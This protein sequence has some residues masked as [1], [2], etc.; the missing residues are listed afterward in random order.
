MLFQMSASA[1]F[2]P[3][4]CSLRQCSEAFAAM[5]HW[6]VSRTSGILTTQA[7]T[8]TA[9]VLAVLSLAACGDS[10]AAKGG[11]AGLAAG[12]P[13]AQSDGGGT[14]ALSDGAVVASARD[15]GADGSSSLGPGPS[16]VGADSAIVPGANGQDGGAGDGA[17]AAYDPSKALPQGALQLHIDLSGDAAVVLSKYICGPI[18]ETISASPASLVTPSVVTRD[19]YA[20]LQL[21]ET[22]DVLDRQMS[23]VGRCSAA[24][25]FVAW[26]DSTM[27]S[28]WS[29]TLVGAYAGGGALYGF[30]RLGANSTFQVLKQ[31]GATI[32]WSDNYMGFLDYS[33]SGSVDR[34]LVSSNDGVYAIADAK[35]LPGEAP[36]MT[37]QRVLIKYDQAG[38]R[39]WIHRL[40]PELAIGVGEKGFAADAAGNLYFASLGHFATTPSSQYDLRVEK[41][42]P[43]GT[44]LWVRSVPLFTNSSLSL[45]LL[46]VA[47]SE[48]TLYVLT[49]GSP[50][51]IDAVNARSI[52]LATFGTLD[53][54]TKFRVEVRS[55]FVKI[56][57]PVEQVEWH[58]KQTPYPPGIPWAVAPLA[59]GGVCVG[60]QFENSYVNGSTPKEPFTG[61]Q[62]FCLDDVGGLRWARQYRGA[63]NPMATTANGKLQQASL[64]PGNITEQADGSLLI[65][66]DLSWGAGPVVF[67]LDAQGNVKN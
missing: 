58:G 6:C 34:L 9:S 49:M 2:L 52:H 47:V 12:P 8:S 55:Q 38:A 10:D 66:A 22:P 24:G 13:G 1:L 57:D 5:S 45:A 30:N 46:R 48:Q 7:W 65:A 17:V 11:D 32:S 50:Q 59:N 19:G 64:Y 14:E 31:D 40:A 63:E 39:Q 44:S 41:L 26:P 51:S 35:Q 62:I 42:D 33:R 28:S 37:A 60:G 3:V 21:P 27:G 29:P 18:V 16:S 23:H 43:S 25:E 56:I 15:G 4:A 67:A 20:F 61:A 36:G 53:G 54:T